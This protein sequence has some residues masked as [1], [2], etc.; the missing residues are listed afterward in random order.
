LGLAAY[1]LES[2]PQGSPD[3][4]VERLTMRPAWSL[5]WFSGTP[6]VYL[7]LKSEIGNGKGTL[8]I[9]YTGGWE[10][11][12][13]GLQLGELPLDA[14]MQSFSLDGT[15]DADV[16][17]HGRTPDEGG[18]LIGQVSFE[19]KDGTVGGADL[20]LALPF[21]KLAGELQFLEQSVIRL[22]K[23]ELAGPMLDAKAEGEIGGSDTAQE[24]PLDLSID[25]ELHDP[26]LAAML[27]L[28]GRRNGPQKLTVTGTLAS[29]V[30][31]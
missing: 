29:P 25:Y 9:G 14:V 6:A 27:G 10:G 30:F 15:L 24:R 18:G 12:I 31:R 2:G 23:L 17:L 1:D 22:V 16:D 3:F 5:Q 28:G 4:R 20:P 19:L 7:D 11:E 26:D 13:R 8:T 21:D